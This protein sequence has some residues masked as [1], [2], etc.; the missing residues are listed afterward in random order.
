MSARVVVAR[1]LDDALSALADA[2]EHAHV[3]AGG[4][5]LMVELRT[6]RTRP[7]LVVDIW[8]LAELRGVREDSAGLRLGA[9]TTCAEI[10]RSER[11]R[12]HCELLATACAEVGAEQIQQRATLGGNLGTASPAADIVP[13][14]MAL[15]ASVRLVSRSASRDVALEEFCI[16]YRRTA[17]RPDELIESVHVPFRPRG[18]RCAFRKVGTR[19][20]QSISKLVV[21]LALELEGARI[22]AARGAAG[23]V[24]PRTLR[25]A[26]LERE[27]L[28]ARVSREL[29][30]RAAAA[31]AREDVQP[32][33][34]LR[35]SAGYRRQVLARVLHSLLCDLT[36][37][38]ACPS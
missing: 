2:D 33:D 16:G 4:T 22:V 30:L 15:G 34:D 14:L 1:S 17:R 18:E 32:I 27:L 10:V 5:D 28:G 13:A 31:A 6:G 35:S 12:G 25:L 36:G 7:S 9:L 29:C 21:A 11:L 38:D 20:A 26:A 19:R 24:A 23:S 37:V 8:K 3:L